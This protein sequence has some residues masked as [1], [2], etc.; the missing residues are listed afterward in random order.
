[1]EFLQ[2]VY[3]ILGFE[4]LQTCLSTRPKKYIGNLQEWSNAESALI[5]AL[6]KRK[7]EYSLNEGDG[8]FYGPKI[9][10]L[11]KDSFGRNHQTATIQ[12]DFQL[13]ER[14]NLT[15]MT[16]KDRDDRPVIIH[17]AVLGS[18]ERMMAI[19]IEHYQGKWPF[20]L[21]PR[22]AIVI[23]V[24]KEFNDYAIKVSKYLSSNGEDLISGTSNHSTSDYYFVDAD[25]SEKTLGKK[26]HDA[27]ALAYNYILVV[28]QK[29]YDSQSVTIRERGTTVNGNSVHTLSLKDA[30]LYFKENFN[31]NH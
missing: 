13:P 17:R 9:D 3:S 7:I 1:M 21:S 19:L 24:R 16:E 8:A 25:I 22:Q 5:S 26:I 20:W 10:I 27:Q 11:V 2:R 30:L 6:E 31:K 15:Y 29:E 14:F 18:I 12:L 4:S 23:A 28:G